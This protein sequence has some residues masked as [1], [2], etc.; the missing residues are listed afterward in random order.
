MPVQRLLWSLLIFLTVWIVS[1]P[2]QAASIDPYVARYLRAVEPVPVILNEQGQTRSFSPQALSE[3]KHLFE[4]N[5]KGCHVGGSTLPNPL[6]S[7]SL[8][9]LQGATP[10]R[11]TINSLV[12][13]L[14]QPMTYDGSEEAVFCRQVPE[15]WLSQAQVENLAA[16]I[17]QAAEK[18]PGWGT[19][20]F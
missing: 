19:N 9:D 6:V 15:S 7:L 10:P 5:C 4:D 8:A 1:P 20:R 2:V 13:Y 17:L 11:A 14:R 3:G 12:A 18:A 16:F